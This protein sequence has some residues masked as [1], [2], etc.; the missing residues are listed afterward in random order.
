MFD[1]GLY[2][3]TKANIHL[4]STQSQKLQTV[5]HIKTD[6]KQNYNQ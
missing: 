2:G 1:H 6:T 4:Y 5:T 3:S